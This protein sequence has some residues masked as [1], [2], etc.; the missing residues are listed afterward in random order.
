MKYLTIGQIDATGIKGPHEK[1]L[2]DIGRNKK[3]NIQKFRYK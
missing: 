3:K 1:E 2:E